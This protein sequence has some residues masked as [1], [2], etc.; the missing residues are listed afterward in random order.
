MENRKAIERVKDWLEGE[1][2][3]HPDDVR[4]LFAAYQSVREERDALLTKS[5]LVD[6]MMPCFTNKCDHSEWAGCGQAMVDA[7]NGSPLA[8]TGGTE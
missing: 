7:F 6:A 3:L 8:R 5:A 4:D 2:T 1:N